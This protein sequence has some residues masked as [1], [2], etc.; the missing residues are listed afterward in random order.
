MI[1][2]THDL[3]EALKL[4][5]RILIMRHGELVQIGTGDEL[6][7]APADDYV[8]DFVSEVPRADVLT[9]RWVARPATPG[10]ADDLGPTLPASTVI[11][12]AVPTIL[13]SPSPVRVLDGDTQLGV[14]DRDDVLKLVNVSR[15]S[16]ALAGAGTAR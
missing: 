15:D 7:G 2:I 3:S 4:G 16:I 9:L 10:N 1:F 5:D 6:V 11:R 13:S 8:A 14:V 12:D